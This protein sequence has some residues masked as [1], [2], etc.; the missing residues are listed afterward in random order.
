MLAR[1]VCKSCTARP[2]TKT[3]P[4]FRCVPSSAFMSPMTKSPEGKKGCSRWTN[5]RHSPGLD[6]LTCYALRHETPR[7]R[8]NHTQSTQ[9]QE[10]GR[11][12]GLERCVRRRGK[13][14]D[15]PL[16]HRADNGR[17]SEAR[18]LDRQMAGSNRGGDAL[19]H[20]TDQ[21]TAK[22]EPQGIDVRVDRLG[23]QRPGESPLLQCPCCKSGD[24]GSQGRQRPRCS[25]GSGP[26]CSELALRRAGYHFADKIVLRGK[27]AIH[28]AC[29]D[30]SALRHGS[31][32]HR[33]HAFL[34]GDRLRRIENCLLTLGEP[35]RNVL[36]AAVGHETS[37]C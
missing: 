4:C 10:R 30:V 22:P 23:S 31:N 9:C 25:I 2:W 11:L 35:A 15:H 12:H 36:R 13:R 1:R 8:I 28:G 33:A 14:S 18:I 26:H 17:R 27:I 16:E 29:G 6:E 34:A 3:Q 7:P 24:A 20:F 37:E 21:C 5:R 19:F 32:L